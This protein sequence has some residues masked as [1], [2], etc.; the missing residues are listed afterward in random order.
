MKADKL[1]IG[2]LAVLVIASLVAFALM[3]SSVLA[4]AV[5][6]QQPSPTIYV[7]SGQT[8]PFLVSLNTVGGKAYYATI[9]LSSQAGLTAS[10]N[11]TAYPSTSTSTT[12]TTIPIGISVSGN[13]GIYQLNITV[14]EYN[15]TTA[16]Q[17]VLASYKYTT[18]VHNYGYWNFAE[19]QVTANRDVERNSSVS[20]TGR[21][22]R[23]YGY[24]YRR[25]T[26][27]ELVSE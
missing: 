13:P 17:S 9:S 10:S 15:S 14:T 22:R 24:I 16:P 12:N 8:I 2:A 6:V 18:Y 5:A 26:A 20:S 27:E 3:V 21:S 4:N 19:L 1:V 23:R 25:K 7:N 11:V